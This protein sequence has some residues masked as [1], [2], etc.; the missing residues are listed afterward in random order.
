VQKTDISKKVRRSTLI[1]YLVNHIKSDQSGMGRRVFASSPMSD[2]SDSDLEFKTP[3]NAARRLLA[4]IRRIEGM[5]D[6]SPTETEELN[7]F[8]SPD[9]SQSFSVHGSHIPIEKPNKQ[10]EQGTFSLPREQILEELQYI[11]HYVEALDEEYKELR[12][13]RKADV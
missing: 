8:E 10:R 2:E 7:L 4:V 1:A 12:P 6:S 5:D 3:T 9:M 13:I 11:R